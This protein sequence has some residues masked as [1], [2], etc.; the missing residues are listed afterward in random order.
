[1]Q[2]IEPTYLRYI[3]DNLQKGSLSADNDTNLPYGFTGIFEEKFGANVSVKVKQEQLEIFTCFALLKK[4]VS[5]S[6]A[7]E[8]LGKD[9]HTIIDLI[10]SHASWFNSPEPGLFKLYHDRLRVFFLQKQSEKVINGLNERIISNLEEAIKD[11]KGDELEYYALEF[12]AHHMFLTSQQ[13]LNEER[14]FDFVFDK[15]VIENQVKVF[16][17]YSIPKSSLNY[18]LSQS[19]RDKSEFYAL[20]SLVL[21]YELAVEARQDINLV[22]NLYLEQEYDEFLVQLRVFPLKT[23]LFLLVYLLIREVEIEETKYDVLGLNKI[24][25]EIDKFQN[26]NSLTWSDYFDEK[27]ILRLCWSLFKINIDAIS[28]FFSFKTNIKTSYWLIYFM[29]LDILK[30]E[31]LLFNKF[32]KKMSFKTEFEL[33]KRSV[34]IYRKTSHLKVKLPVEVYLSEYI[35]YVKWSDELKVQYVKKLSSLKSRVST[36]KNTKLHFNIPDLIA[37][38]KMVKDKDFNGIL[39][40][41]RIARNEYNNL[42]KRHDVLKWNQIRKKVKNINILEALMFFPLTEVK[43]I[44]IY[45]ITNEG[46]K[47]YK[48]IS[49]SEKYMYMNNNPDI[50]LEFYETLKNKFPNLLPVNYRYDKLCDYLSILVKSNKIKESDFVFDYMVSF[51]SKRGMGEGRLKDTKEISLLFKSLNTDQADKF[52]QNVINKTIEISS[53]YDISDQV[54]KILLSDYGVEYTLTYIQKRFKEYELISLQLLISKIL[55]EKG[56]LDTAKN[57]FKTAE[58]HFFA[59]KSDTPSDRFWRP[60]LSAEFLKSNFVSKA[61]DI[62]RFL[63][64][65]DTK[66][67]YYLDILIRKFFINDKHKKA[68]YY[69]DKYLF[70][71][72]EI[73]KTWN[74]RWPIEGLGRKYMRLIYISKQFNLNLE[75]DPL[76]RLKNSIKIKDEERFNT[77]ANYY[78]TYS[79]FYWG[80]YYLNKMKSR[81]NVENTLVW[82]A[83]RYFMAGRYLDGF[84]NLTKSNLTSDRSRF[85]L[86][87]WITN[88]PEVD[89]LG[90]TK[91]YGNDEQ[92]KSLKSALTVINISSD[93]FCLFKNSIYMNELGIELNEVL[94]LIYAKNIFVDTHENKLRELL[95]DFA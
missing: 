74:K 54:V 56:D 58:S 20:K 51:V 61:P 66:K 10:E 68:F 15:T 67:F 28:T 6:F 36:I 40:S 77:L 14:L 47:A 45:I 21:K 75:F 33:P 91:K 4:E 88:C 48:T 89:H 84:K 32:L 63:S 72:L 64:L 92:I 29:E 46:K 55:L 12:L 2:S 13:G 60:S 85:F 38:K 41:I 16:R 57:I 30:E 83:N 3:Y 35:K 71:L 90:I 81:I 80:E 5:I 19:T 11:N 39:E 82:S 1:M 27:S 17:N 22:I 62:N 7:A 69:L 86:K 94:S 52:V 65:D 23:R 43:D 26:M 50:V 59:I 8:V 25:F 70:E 76:K 73:N 87:N 24:I 53:K 49:R 34:E 18:A 9:E 37:L 78:F 31:I 44:I 93:N 95:M 42:M 79:N